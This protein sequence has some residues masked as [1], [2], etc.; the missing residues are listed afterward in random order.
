MIRFFD[1]LISVNAF[2][3]FFPLFL[4]LT[5]IGWIDTGAPIL[6]QIRVG[7]SQK[8]FRIFKFRTMKTDTAF[9]PSHLVNKNALTK[10]GR[11]TRKL[12]FDELPQFINV[13]FG[14]MSIVGPRPCLPNQNI[15]ISKRQKLNVYDVRP[16]ITGLAQIKG[17]DM[18][19]PSLLSK[20]DAELVKSMN[21]KTY[22]KII[23]LT[24]I[25]RGFGDRVN[26]N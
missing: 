2:I 26:Y 17:V 10:V 23:A 1:I 3:I 18:S 25:G 12:K 15:L 7:K 21:L 20:L 13:M 4:I 22:F 5:I 24:I 14:D 11:I 9:V 8:K 19:N 16:G 6:V